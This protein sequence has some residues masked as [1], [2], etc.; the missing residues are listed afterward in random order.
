MKA[1]QELLVAALE[2]EGEAQRL[3]LGGDEE[4]AREAFREVAGL[5][6]RSWD[7]APPTAFGRLT[8]ML[9]AAIL[10]GGGEEEAVFARSQVGAG[11]T[12]AAAYVIALAALV[13]RDD[14]TAAEAARVMADGDDAHRRA[15]AA[16]AALAAGD[17]E[18]Y[19]EAVRTIVRD[20]ETRESHLTGVPIADTAIVMERLAEGRGIATAP[21]SPVLP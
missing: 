20:F 13:A 1:A 7:E 12:P 9:K 10:A 15:A 18:G 17:R 2:R 16:I 4:A 8:G 3:L 14:R 19:G 6:R 21:A 11:E 5:Y